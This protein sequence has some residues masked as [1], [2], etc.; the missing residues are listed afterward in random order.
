[1]N[2]IETIL[3]IILAV[4]V[5]VSANYISAIWASKESK[6]SIWLF[7]LIIIAPLVF[8]TFGI[9]TSKLGLALTSA[10]VDSLLTIA[11]IFVGLIILKEW[12]SI[13]LYQVIGMFFA[14]IGIILMHIQK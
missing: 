3:Y 11:T 14:C 13:S 1:M 5:A 9:V 10:T 6:I 7:A 8:I 4:V 12:G 2:K